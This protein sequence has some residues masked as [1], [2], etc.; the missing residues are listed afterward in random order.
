MRRVLMVTPHFPPDSSAAS[1]RVRLL[2]P[3]LP[4]AGWRPTVVTL[5][6]SGYEGRLAPAPAAAEGRPRGRR[7][8]AADAR[9]RT[10][11]GRVA[12]SN[13][14]DRPRRSGA[15]CLHRLAARLPPAA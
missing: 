14:V 4:A 5:E 10:R 2:A 9:D 8:R 7:R 12:V 3:H 6:P 13:A 11:A 15:A 1:H